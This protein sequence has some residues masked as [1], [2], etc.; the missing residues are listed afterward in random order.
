M[1]PRAALHDLGNGG[2]GNRDGVRRQDLIQRRDFNGQYNRR[3]S[4]LSRIH[5]L[6]A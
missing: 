5:N 4:G 3:C 1:G 6:E 2:Q